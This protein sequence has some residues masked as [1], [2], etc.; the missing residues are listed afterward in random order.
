MPKAVRTLF[1][2]FFFALIAIPLVAQKKNAGY[3]YHL[4]KTTSEVKVDGVEDDLAW[5]NSEVAADFFMV[6]PMDT[7]RAR[8]RTEVRMTYDDEHVYLMATCYN[9]L[10]GP[11][12]GS[13][14]RSRS[15]PAAR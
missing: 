11:W 12:M 7:S 14:A 2:L 9:L 3:Q 10:P 8:V 5:K 1:S 13:P 6:L 4:R 15:S